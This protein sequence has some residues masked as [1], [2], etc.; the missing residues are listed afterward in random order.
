MKCLE[1]R[2]I[3]WPSSHRCPRLE[4]KKQAREANTQIRGYR[5]PQCD[6]TRIGK[7]LPNGLKRPKSPK[8]FI[9]CL[10]TCPVPC[11]EPG[12]RLFAVLPVNY[13]DNITES[14][15]S[16][17]DGDYFRFIAK[18]LFLGWH[19]PRATVRT[20]ILDVPRSHSRGIAEK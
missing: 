18:L 17:K 12:M 13:F 15:H 20:L 10:P 11:Q 5:F 2:P 1:W 4:R 3:D 8:Y 6:T 16:K 9:M 19:F 7:V 14:Q